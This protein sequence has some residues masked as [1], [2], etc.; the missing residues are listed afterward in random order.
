MKPWLL[1]ILA[2]PIDKHHPLEAYFLSWES[3]ETQIEKL[4]AEQGKPNLELNEKYKLLLK[5]INDGTISPE[6]IKEIKD[7]TDSKPS[8]QM[9]TKTIEALEKIKKKQS[10]A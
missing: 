1:N 9:L 5:Q 4:A 8:K 2:C 6:A 10:L 7:D 3:E